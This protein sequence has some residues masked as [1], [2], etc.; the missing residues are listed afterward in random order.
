MNI[1]RM[2]SD[3]DP[4][5]A[6]ITKLFKN[7]LVYG[8]T[9]SLQSIL[10][11]VLLPIL[12]IYYTPEIFGVYSLLLLLSALS[13]AIFYLGASSALG[14]FYLEEN[15][16]LY[17][18]KIFTTSLIITLIGA[19]LLISLGL[20]FEKPLSISLFETDK[21]HLPV[22]LILIATSFGFL[23]NLMTLLL[24]YENKASLFFIIIISGIL[25]NFIITYSLLSKFNYGILAPIYGVLI[26]NALLFF[27]LI[28]IK[29]KNLTKKL[30]VD[31]FKLILSFG[32]QSSIA[33]LS[34]YLLEWIDRLI[35]NELLNLNDVGI[36]SL[37]YKLGAII[38]ILIV[39]PFSLVWG[40]MRMQYAKSEALPSYT[41]KVV[42]YYTLIGVFV[43]SVTILFGE[44]ILKIF[45]TNKSYANSILIVPIIMFSLFFYGYQNIIDFGIY[46]NNKIYYYTVI[47]A[48]LILVNVGLNFW[49][50]P[51]FGYQAAAYVTL[52][53]YF[54][55]SSIIYLV[56]SFY[57]PIKIEFTR[58]FS[59]LITIPILYYLVNFSGGLNF[60][61]RIIIALTIS[62]MFYTLWLNKTERAYMVQGI[63][64]S[65]NTKK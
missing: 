30:E 41:V 1:N 60:S 25:V 33:G 12:T 57:Y 28:L 17:K 11:F 56:S 49:L 14:R 27:I 2:R 42:S 64:K 47:A 54:L 45:F 44:D 13:S 59:A 39:V 3:I 36:Y 52:F 24:R 15:S 46:I 10:G 40:P 50:L 55:S 6:K 65:L 31:H 38:N 58:V 9:S 62:L 34:F 35:I 20:I 51:S 43:L 22:K 61:I 16:D 4:F 23:L 8:L 19:F 29:I 5:S 48:V 7:S 53:T 21:Y 37:G 18:N 26:S 63:K 32:T